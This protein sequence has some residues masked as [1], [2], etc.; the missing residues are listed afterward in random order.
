MAD[1]VVRVIRVR[2]V[3][4]GLENLTAQ[5]KRAEQ[6]YSGISTAASGAGTATETSARKLNTTERSYRS[7]SERLDSTARLY[8]QLQTDTRTLSGAFDAG[9]MGKGA[10]A[11]ARF[12]AQLR[13]IQQTLQ[14]VGSARATG[15]AGLD[16]A[17][18]IGRASASARDSAAV[19]EAEMQR[20]DA[21]AQQRAAQIGADFGREL[22]ERLVSGTGK[23]ARDSA[24]VFEAEMSRL[25]DIARQRAAQAGQEFQR[26]LN[27][28][29]VGG[30]GKSASASAAVFQEAFAAQDAQARTIEKL[31]QQY[32]PLGVA[33]ERY[34]TAVDETNKALR[35]GLIS[36]TQHVTIT[37][38]ARKVLD[39]TVKSYNGAFVAQGKYA[40][41]AGLARH[42]LVN[43]SRQIQDVGVSLASGQS[44]LTVLIQQGTQIADVFAASRASVSGFLAQAAG[45][46]ARFAMSGAGLAT[47]GALA[48]GAALLAGYQYAEGQR[49]VERSLAGVGRQSGVTLAA[50]N[51]LADGYADAAKV[52]T[53]TARE[54]IAAFAGTGKVDAATIGGTARLGRDFA[55][56]MGLS[57][58]DSAKQLA[59]A[60]ADPTAGAMELNKQ[61]GFLDA[62]TLEYIR[63]A[64]A[65]GRISEAQKALSEA[66]GQSIA[67]AADRTSGLAR[68]WNAV[69]NAAS[70]AWDAI[71]NAVG[72]QVT[73]EE[74]LNALIERRR[75]M[76]GGLRSRTASGQAA[77]SR[78]DDQ[79]A[80][81]QEEMRF[82]NRL[83]A[84]QRASARASAASTGALSVLDEINPFVA[85]LR[86]LETMA[87]ALK[88]GMEE[89]GNALNPDQ[90]RQVAEAYERIQRAIQQ[91]L[92]PAERQRQMNE[93]TVQSIM[94]RT[95]AERTAADVARLQLDSAFKLKETEEQRLI[96]LGKI[97]EAQAQAN[98][99]ARDALRS[100]RDQNELAGL[101]PYQRRLREI[102][103]RER[104]N[105]ERFGGVAAP[106][107][108][109]SM[110][111]DQLLN[112]I[113]RFESGG[114]NVPNYKFGPGFTAQGH[115]QITNSTWKDIAKAAG[116]DLGQYPNA[117][118]APYD[119]Q[120]RAA[121]ALVDQR[122][123][124]PWAPHNPALRN[125]LGVGGG[126][127]ATGDASASTIAG[128][129]K[130][131][132][133]T[134][135]YNSIIRSAND[136]LSAQQRQLQATRDTMFMSTEEVAKAQKTQELYNQAVQEG[137]VDLANKL[138]PEI[139][140]TAAG[141][142]VLAR[143][144][145]ELQRAQEAMKT[146]GDLG[147]SVIS[148]MVSDLRNGASGADMFRNALD[149]IASKLLDMAL[150]D[151]FGKAFGNN[152]M[153]L[154]GGGGFFSSLLGGFGGGGGSIVPGTGGLIAV[155]SGGGY[156]VGGYTGPGGKY[157]PAGIVHRNEYVFSSASVNRLGVGYLDSLHRSSLKGYADGGYVS[158]APYLTGAGNDNAANSNAPSKV[159]VQIVNQTSGQ[160]EGSATTRQNPDGS[161]EVMIDL[162]EARM[163]Q[164]FAHGHGSLVQ[165][166]GARQTNRHLRG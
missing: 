39:D 102:E 124:Q 166:V 82:A 67:G 100:A 105:R 2:G 64:Q 35:A 141:Y 62:R 57:A 55:A 50:V 38:N 158:P 27:E 89:A 17:F 56:Q 19:F 25:D 164:R 21:I 153:G 72:G 52:S 53:A 40:T 96:I 6:A 33:Q 116:I 79:I 162:V 104:D 30:S 107:I 4:E 11:A 94:A 7:L 133:A 149:K 81:Q 60:F 75:N 71:G 66:L 131:T 86:K 85:E 88:K 152:A 99:E 70:G 18:G 97:N 151:L 28:R 132:A 109:N 110:S 26:A 78:A 77:M 46:V 93:L 83:A 13:Q 15:N 42:E 29:L 121:N 45:G 44:P 41:G 161:L 36:E 150:N 31:R 128:L 51:R 157:S 120:R 90:A 12:N 84:Q 130:S 92:P 47:G 122:G 48:G 49:E 43:L 114:R 155:G 24:A 34:A 112:A 140:K 54:M 80:F 59:G 76:E 23:S 8:R 115:F 68:A 61:I 123:V 108:N 138:L 10:E 125:W 111:R 95:L 58:G 159:N 126:V 119:V 160:V 146:I 16:A 1:E 147:R 14:D 145:E 113:E 106:G 129:E 98:R 65:Q 143:Q 22:S 148:G 5:L 101:R 117:M 37:A 136:N 156:A 103:L 69:W 74:R 9:F 3:P 32:D 134:E 139:L 91:A 73:A 20:L 154:F 63:T 135:A 163:A 118:S 137:G 127:A 165:A 142:G 87:S 144:T